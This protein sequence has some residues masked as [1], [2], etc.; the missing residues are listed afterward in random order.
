MM[1]E[2]LQIAEQIKQL[3]PIRTRINNFSEEYPFAWFICLDFKES[4]DPVVPD[5]AVK[6]AH[7]WLRHLARV[8][9]VHFSPFIAVE[10]IATGKRMSVHII[11]RADRYLTTRTLRES[12]KN[13]F[14]WVRLYKP[15]LLGVEYVFNHHIGASTHVVCHG[16]KPC[17]VNRKGRVFCGKETQRVLQF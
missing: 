14:A 8:H 9:R 6:R 12:W 15:T 3:G 11:L 1:N 16:K 13:G 7:G 10:P 2:Q 4:C 5:V 17:R